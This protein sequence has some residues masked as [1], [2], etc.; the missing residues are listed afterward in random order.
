[1]LI[2]RN[3][4]LGVELERRLA[5]LGNVFATDRAKLDLASTDAVRRAVREARP[6]VIVNA[7]AYTA[8][9]RAE[10]ERA[11]AMQVNGAA[12]GVLAEEAGRL[13]ALLVHYSSDY[14]FDGAKR[15]AYVED[16]PTNPLNA[17]G[18]SKL[19]GEQ[20]VRASGARALLLRASWIYAAH[21]ANF[22]RTI[23][24]RAA[25]GERLR[26]VDDQR[27]VPTPAAFVAAGTLE[28]LRK[29]AEG[30]FHLVPAGEAS[31]FEFARAI[32]DHLGARAPL[33]AVA[34]GE[35]PDPVRRPPYSV[36]DNAKAARALGHPFEH[37]Q[38]L[39]AAM[40]EPALL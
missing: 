16:D 26:V 14:V 30:L 6:D 31:W 23:A 12:P 32:L 4:Q 7:A 38:D 34:T 2:G 33:E 35:Y 18:A 10:G 39:L 28:L 24:A 40:A 1:M 19:E 36:L 22:Y 29:G 27:G 21:G 20:R 3:G 11:L 8:V 15:S 37:W 13:G 9:A 17:Y 25:A 5:S